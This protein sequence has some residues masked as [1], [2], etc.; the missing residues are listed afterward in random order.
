MFLTDN[1]PPH[2]D[3]CFSLP[4]RAR[5]LEWGRMSPGGRVSESGKHVPPMR[6]GGEGLIALK[7]ADDR[8]NLALD[9]AVR[10]IDIDR[11]HRRVG[12]L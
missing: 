3:S 4:L 6:N 11:I 10:R 5:R 12:G 2:N 1:N 8:Q 7:L 9:L